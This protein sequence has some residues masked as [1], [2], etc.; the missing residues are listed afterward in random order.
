MAGKTWKDWAALAVLLAMCFGVAFA[1]SQATTTG[2]GTWYAKLAKPTWNPPGW[3]FGPV[4][5]VLYAMM[6]LA[7]WLVWLRRDRRPVSAAM[8]LFVVQLAL[9]GAWSW[10][11]FHFHRVD[12]ALV[13]I[14]LLLVMIAA[15]LGAFRKVRPAAAVLLIPY[16]LWVLFATCLNGAIWSLNR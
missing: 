13:N 1:G 11:F 5:T 16:L 14:A 15:T 7:A 9:N 10:V 12:L 8:A 2:V 6:A 4:W 3:V